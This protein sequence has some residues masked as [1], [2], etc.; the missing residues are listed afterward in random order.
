MATQ[1]KIVVLRMDTKR[2]QSETF[3]TMGEALAFA[4]EVPCQC[5]S[6]LG[7]LD[8]GPWLK[9]LH[10]DPM[11]QVQAMLKKPYWDTRVDDYVEAT[12]AKRNAHLIFS[13]LY[14]E[15]E[16]KERVTAVRRLFE[17]LDEL[18]VDPHIKALAHACFDG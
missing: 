16:K 5:A 18:D 6:L 15:R 13:A 2:V 12:T 17:A 10:H 3:E 1:F 14:I 8:D 7:K 11:G 9:G 4:D